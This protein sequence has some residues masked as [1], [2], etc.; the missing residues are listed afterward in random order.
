[1]KNKKVIGLLII[2]ASIICVFSIYSITLNIID[3]KKS[4]NE[5]NNLDKLK[6]TYDILAQ[7]SFLNEKIKI[8]RYYLTKRDFGEYEAIYD[9]QDVTFIS[10]SKEWDAIKLE[11]LYNELISNTYGDEFDYLTYVALYAEDGSGYI[12][13]NPPYVK[14]E[15]EVPIS[16]YM[17]LPKNLKYM[18]KSDYNSLAL[19]RCDEITTVQEMAC[20]LSYEYG[21]HFA[22]HHLDI[23][24]DKDDINTEYYDLRLKSHIDDVVLDVDSYQEY[25]DNYIW[26]SWEMAAS[27]YVYLMGS[28]AT[29]Q[30]F[31]FYDTKDRMLKY[32]ENK[33][34]NLDNYWYYFKMGKNVLPIDNHM[35]PM[36][37]QV[38]GLKELF[39]SYVDKDAPEYTETDNIGDLNLKVTPSKKNPKNQFRVT[40]DKP[41]TD[42][43]VVYTLILYNMKDEIVAVHKTVN[44]NEEALARFGIYQLT[45]GRYIYTYKGWI[46]LTKEYKLRVTITF[47]DSTV[48]VSDSIEVQFTKD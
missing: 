18:Y 38:G 35:I 25:L 1:M 21:H 13:K 33:G 6:S 28:N 20:Y 17:F 46:D 44:G 8:R 29:K 39:Y 2:L 19:K 23:N 27:D 3:Y 43:D 4:L 14:E 40:W 11:Q 10:Y 45:Y 48:V 15:Y 5:F 26:Y 42:E 34:R 41:Y 47:P 12:S 22:L 31:E 24:G 32:A 30:V 7:N 16:L 37:H 9:W 36:P